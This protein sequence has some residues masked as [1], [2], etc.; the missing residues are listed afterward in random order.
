MEDPLFWLG[1]SALSGLALA[2]IGT[3]FLLRFLWEVGRGLLFVASMV[4]AK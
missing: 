1:V 3:Y 4:R 2:G